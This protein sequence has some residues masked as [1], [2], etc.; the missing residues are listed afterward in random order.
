MKLNNIEN[1]VNGLFGF[2]KKIS[3]DNTDNWV[4]GL[5]G[6]TGGSVHLIIMNV[7]FSFVAVFQAV[8]TAFLCGIAGILGKHF[9]TWVAREI[10]RE[11]NQ[12]PK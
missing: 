6:F 5:F 10:K 4:A 11:N 7:E 2:T 3:H 12:S 8:V 9:I 1:W